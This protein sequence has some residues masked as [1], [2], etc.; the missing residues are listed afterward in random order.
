[1]ALTTNLTIVRGDSAAWSVAITLNGSAY[2]LFG[3]SL[4]FTV[5]ASPNDADVDA[6]IVRT[7]AL[8]DGI[9]ITD[10]N[11]GLARLTLGTTH[12]AALEPGKTYVWDLQ[13][14]SAAGDVYTPDGLRGLV[15][16]SADVSRTT[17]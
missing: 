2:S 6:V 11:A 10:A 9:A 13:I 12:T 5:K 3:A 1:M 15:Y 17:P 16:V 4:R 14:T 8:G 7:T